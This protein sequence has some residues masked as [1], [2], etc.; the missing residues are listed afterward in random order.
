MAGP[1][2][3]FS[4]FLMWLG[5]LTYVITRIL[6]RRDK[7]TDPNISVWIRDFDNIV[8]IVFSIILTYILIRFYSGYQDKL[9]TALPEGLKVTPYFA[10]FLVGILQHKIS[11]MIK[12]KLKKL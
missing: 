6:N 9:T 5:V 8:A 12:N 2:W 4:V 7:D 11:E 3:C 10:M 1:E